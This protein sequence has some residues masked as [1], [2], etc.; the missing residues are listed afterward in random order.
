MGKSISAEEQN[1][2]VIVNI[3]G[4]YKPPFRSHAK[5]HGFFIWIHNESYIQ[6][7]RRLNTIKTQMKSICTPSP[8]LLL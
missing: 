1:K 7:R 6:N 3:N 2:S 8:W 4:A 5:Q